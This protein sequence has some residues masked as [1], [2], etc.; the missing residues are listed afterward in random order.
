MTPI[1]R[2]RRGGSAYP[3][4]VGV[5]A[6]TALLIPFVSGP[7]APNAADA[8]AD[9]AP[10]LSART[11]DSPGAGRAALRWHVVG[12]TKLPPAAEMGRCL[13][14]HRY[15]KAHPVA[16]R[17]DGRSGVGLRVLHVALPAAVRI[18]PLADAPDTWVITT[19]VGDDRRMAIAL[20]VVVA[21]CLADDA[22][23]LVDPRLGR[24]FEADAWPRPLASGGFPLAAIV[25]VWRRPTHA[26]TRGLAYLGLPEIVL[27]SSDD[28]QADRR[29]LEHSA[30]G[31]IAVG[32]P[33]EGQLTGPENLD[34]G[35]VLA[36]ELVDADWL[37]PE[38]RG[39][40]ETAVL[41]EPGSSPWAPLTSRTSKPEAAPEPERPNFIDRDRPLPRDTD[42]AGAVVPEVPARDQ[43]RGRFMPDYR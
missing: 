1:A 23:A 16:A 32:W 6:L 43:S 19:P 12:R 40:A 10:R 39:A 14:K 22:R 37:P 18:D 24:R 4:V 41:I 42:G 35:L 38:I 34:V 8:G 30:A 21:A 11:D 15:P 17:A 13:R 33:S 26:S 5:V 20:H 29:T 9:V 28:E 7:S 36:S 3:L 2:R 25:D 27:M 31:L